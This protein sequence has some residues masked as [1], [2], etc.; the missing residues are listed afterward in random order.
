[1]GNSE[2]HQMAKVYMPTHVLIH[3]MNKRERARNEAER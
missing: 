2:L 1:M 3:D